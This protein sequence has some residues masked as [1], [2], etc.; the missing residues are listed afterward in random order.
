MIETIESNVCRETTGDFLFLITGTDL[1]NETLIQFLCIAL[2][3]MCLF[4]RNYVR[5]L[6]KEESYAAAFFLKC[7]R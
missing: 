4:K 7:F 2:Q 3:E 1:I 5:Y 6:T